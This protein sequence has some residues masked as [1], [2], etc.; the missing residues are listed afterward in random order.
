MA[1]KKLTQ[2]TKSS[3]SEYIAGVF[4]PLPKEISDALTAERRSIADVGTNV[5]HSEAHLT[6]YLARYSLANFT[7]LKNFLAKKPLAAPKIQVGNLKFAHNKLTGNVFVSV[8]MK[9]TAEVQR[10][11]EKFLLAGNQF[12]DGMTRNKDV[13]RMAA[14]KYSAKEVR[15]TKKYGFARVRDLFGPHVSIGEIGHD[16]VLTK[17]KELEKRLAP[18]RKQSFY[19]PFYYVGVYGSDPNGG[20]SKIVKEEKLE[21]KMPEKTGKPEKR[22][23]T[24]PGRSLSRGPTRDRDDRRKAGLTYSTHSL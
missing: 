8:G 5:Y 14:G 21:L 7:K 9:K 4:L 3:Q 16:D 6:F 2:G 1:T 13:A 20:Y 19:P 23:S 22:G 12:R 11:H 17:R 18:L 24:G 15:Y 10:L